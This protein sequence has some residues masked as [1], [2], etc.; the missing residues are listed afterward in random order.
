MSDGS[1]MDGHVFVEYI[2][3]LTLKIF[4]KWNNIREKR[5]LLFGSQR[6]VLEPHL[7]AVALSAPACR[8]RVL[9]TA[10]EAY[11]EVKAA[12]LGYLLLCCVG[13]RHIVLLS[14][15]RGLINTYSE[16]TYR[17]TSRSLLP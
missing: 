4:Q 17:T 16:N 15:G 9:A 13:N 12:V 8:Y 14:F 2:S 11:L 10:P 6:P 3:Q 7:V 5:G 1:A